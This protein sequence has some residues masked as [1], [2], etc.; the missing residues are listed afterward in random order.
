M[1]NVEFTTYTLPSHWASYFCYSD[2][3]GLD[4]DDQAAAD[5]FIEGENLGHYVGVR[6]DVN[7][8]TYHDA[9]PYGVLATDCCEFIFEARQEA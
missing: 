5:A 3:T 7:F 8:M 4:D 2:P 6:G 1:A 9:R